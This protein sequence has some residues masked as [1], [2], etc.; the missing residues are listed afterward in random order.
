VSHSADPFLQME[1]ALFLALFVFV[2]IVFAVFLVLRLRRK[3]LRRGYSP[4]FG[5]LGNALQRLHSIGAPRIE[6]V[7]QE[8]EREQSDD[9]DE[10]GPETAGRY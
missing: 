8:Q 5:A 10:G 2:V 7:L 3:M 9:G 6:Y 4:S 1:V